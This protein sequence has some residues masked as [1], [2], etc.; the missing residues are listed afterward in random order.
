MVE[1]IGHLTL[2]ETYAKYAN[3][4]PKSQQH[5]GAYPHPKMQHVDCISDDLLHLLCPMSSIFMF[6]SPDDDL[7]E[8]SSGHETPASSSSR[9]DLDAEEGKKKKTKGK[10]KD[11]KSKGKKKPDE[12][13]E[14][15]EKKTKRKG[16]ALL[17]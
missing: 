1:G 16:F 6:P 14:D 15:A 3:Y 7:S 13:V 10:K 11:K 5:S 8:H 4:L 9:Q 17:R 2:G 12:S